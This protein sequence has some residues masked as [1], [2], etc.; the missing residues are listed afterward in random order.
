MIINIVS[1]IRNTFFII[2]WFPFSLNGLSAAEARV[3]LNAVFIGYNTIKVQINQ[4][5]EDGVDD[6]GCPA[7]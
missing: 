7:N 5:P 6:Q 3:L 4:K 2:K 1:L